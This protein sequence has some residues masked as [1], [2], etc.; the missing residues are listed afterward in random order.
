MKLLHNLAALL[1]AN[2]AALDGPIMLCTDASLEY[3]TPLY[4]LATRCHKAQQQLVVKHSESLDPDIR[5]LMVDWKFIVQHRWKQKSHINTLE[6]EAVLFGLMWLR[7]QDMTREER[8]LVLVD[9]QV[10]YCLVG[11]GRTS[12]L[13]PVRASQRTYALLL[14][15]ELLLAPA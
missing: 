14:A 1:H 12:A 2:W 4:A 13:S 15:G 9:S 7:R 6:A 8:A 5:L 11:K 3:G 10:L